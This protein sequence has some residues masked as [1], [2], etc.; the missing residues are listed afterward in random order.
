LRAVERRVIETCLR[1]GVPPRAEIY[2]VDAAK[3]YL[4][5]GVRHFRVGTD[6]GI[7]YSW[8]RENGELLRKTVEAAA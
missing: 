6:L 1:A 2:S 7:L 4:D 5:L 3:Y 8:L